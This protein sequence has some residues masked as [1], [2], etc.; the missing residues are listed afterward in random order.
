[1]LKQ[2][3]PFISYPYTGEDTACALCGAADALL[4]CS[5]DRRWKPLRSVA[6]VQCGLIRTAPMPT[7]DELQSYYANEYRADYQFAGKTPPKFHRARSMREAE[8]RLA[9]LNEVIRPGARVL[10]VGCGSG[11]F[12]DVAQK[13]GCSVVGIDPGST[14]VDFARSAYGVDVLPVAW[15]EA[16]FGDGAFDVISCHH[17]LEHL[18]E[19]VAALR[20]MVRWLKPDGRIYLS[21][22][23][24]R[25]N[26]KPSFERFHFAH[27]HGFTPETLQ[28]TA[29]AAGLVAV[30]GDL[31]ATTDIFRKASAAEL[32][33]DRVRARIIDRGRAGRL[34]AGYPDDSIATYVFRGG[35]FRDAGRRFAKWRRDTFS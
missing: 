14:Y 21:V 25:P 24:M 29:A 4:L 1:M 22:P 16:T 7:E 8:Q 34:Q 2:H 26:A 10:D 9:L 12:L 6:C 15:N 28:G 20:A 17:V 27:I 5:T 19:P 31:R 30:D 11:E 23:D 32:A 18:R 33:L 3:L 13:Q 35:W